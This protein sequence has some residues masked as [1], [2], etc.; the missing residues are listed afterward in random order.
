[1][2]SVLVPVYNE[3]GS[4]RTLLTRIEASPVEK[5]IIIVDDGSDDGT[6]EV[7]Q[8]LASDR[9]TLIAHHRNYGKGA[10][11]RTALEFARGEYVIIESDRPG[12][13]A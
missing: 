9:M 12:P 8:S 6:R 10:A 7:V 13:R 2:L 5:E 3:I 4:V 1:L 11:I